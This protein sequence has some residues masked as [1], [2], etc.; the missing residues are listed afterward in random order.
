MV[1]TIH[2]TSAQTSTRHAAEYREAHK[3]LLEKA[4]TCKPE[5]SQHLLRL[6]RLTELNAEHY[7]EHA[8]EDAELD[9]L[10]K[11]CREWPHDES[12]LVEIEDR[13]KARI[14]AIMD[15]MVRVS[16]MKVT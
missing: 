14:N 2:E 4:K 11:L 5:M 13:P 3:R 12:I 10:F 1:D 6:A 7:D 9:R 15:E 16:K 8:R